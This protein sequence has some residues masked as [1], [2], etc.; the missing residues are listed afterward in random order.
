MPSRK[1]GSSDAPSESRRTSLRRLSSIASFQTLFNRRRSNNTEHAA[2]SSSSNLSLSSTIANAPEPA[3]STPQD[4]DSVPDLP[5]PPQPTHLPPRRSSHICLSDDPIG[6]MPRSRTFSNLP[7]PTRAKKT[8]TNHIL[9]SKSH[10]RLPSALLPSTRLPSP[11]IT[12]RKHSHSRLASAE[13]HKP[14]TLRNRMRRSDTEPL[15]GVNMHGEQQSHA[16]HG[17]QLPRSTAFKEN[18]SLSPIK[19]LPALDINT[20]ASSSCAFSSSNLSR[21]LHAWHEHSDG[22]EPLLSLSPYAQHP[23]VQMAREHKSSPA[24]RHSQN[25]QGTPGAATS[26]QR[27]NSQPMLTN[28]TNRNSQ[29]SEVKQT[30]LMSARQPPTPPA[31]KTPFSSSQNPKGGK[32]KNINNSASTTHILST[33]EHTPLLSRST[34]SSKLP[35]RLTPSPP[36]QPTPS[37]LKIWHS[38]PPAYWSGRLSALLDRYRNEDLHTSNL[39]S[40]S[41]STHH[42]PKSQTDALHAPEA[43]T[44]R[45][46]RAFEYLHSQCGSQEAQESLGHFQVQYA[47]NLKVP[48]LAR[49][50]V[51]PIRLGGGKV[52]TEGNGMSQGRKAS[53]MERLLGKGG[54]GGVVVA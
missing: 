37:P 17:S 34:G 15:L 43:T 3:A 44:A 1:S 35:F 18:I 41:S 28:Q 12:T 7:L 13:N 10:S 4:E 9:P 27:W 51:P 14:P 53:F 39:L 25:R 31:P 40:P 26:F 47:A 2:A 8:T 46:R 19:P 6:G 29:H 54:R 32:T 48:E 38:E 36:S 16:R 24:N 22:S 5:P 45:L 30:R 42:T 11:P 33:S 49:Y 21:S 23:G 20:Y 50:C 52:T